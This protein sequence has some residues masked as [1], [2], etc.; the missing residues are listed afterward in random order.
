MVVTKRRPDLT[1]AP[2]GR[3]EPSCAASGV[4]V[5]RHSA[6]RTGLMDAA[7]RRSAVQLSIICAEDLDG[8]PNLTGAPALALTT[9]ARASS[10]THVT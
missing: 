4:F 7:C 2:A 10:V 1:A 9:R 5:N 6:G 3:A 8:K